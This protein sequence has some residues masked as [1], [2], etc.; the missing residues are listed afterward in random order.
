M[1]EILQQIKAFFRTSSLWYLVFCSLWVAVLIF[2][3]YHFH[4]RQNWILEGDKV[5]DWE[6]LTFV[7]F[8]SYF[9][10][11]GAYILIERN[12]KILRNPWFW[13]ITGLSPAVFALAS[14][15][16]CSDLVPPPLTTNA[17]NF[18]KRSGAWISQ[19]LIV[20]VFCISIWYF[21][22][23]KKM[24]LY[25]FDWKGH[26]QKPYWIMLAIMLVPILI[27]GTTI[28]FQEKYPRLKSILYP[29]DPLP[30]IQYLFFELAYAFNFLGIEMF[31]RGFLIGALANILGKEAIL[32]T[33]V[34]YVSIH[35]GKPLGEC[36]SS[37]FGGT[38]LGI[39]SYH[40]NSIKGGLLVHIGIAW[41]MELSGALGTWVW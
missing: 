38:L 37:Y 26:S 40:S 21:K 2:V 8:V 31:F 24:K 39:I 28:D 4:I 25:G 35:F 16:N 19:A 33:A 17:Q 7:Y 32:A 6:R 15:L 3:N 29:D 34:F 41:L 27:A 11:I 30:K 18:M 22:D 9:V 23:R 5:Q 1:A 20:S 13:I 14:V 12:W 36:I 10:P